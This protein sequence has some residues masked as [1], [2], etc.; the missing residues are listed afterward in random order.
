MWLLLFNPT[1]GGGKGRRYAEQSLSLMRQ[2]GHEVVEISGLDFRDAEAKFKDAV[3]AHRDQ[4]KAVIVVG[5]DGMVHMAI[6]Q[7]AGSNIPMGLVPAGTGNDFARAL[8]LNLS[9]PLSSLKLMLNSDPVKVDLGKVND[10]FFADILS[11]GFDSVVNERANRMR[12]IKGRMKYNIAILLVL[13]T[14]KPKSYQFRVDGIEFTTEAMLIAVSNGQSYG[15]GMKVTPDARIDDGLFDVMLLGPVSKLE[16]LKVFPKVF[17]G[18]HIDHP[19]VNIMRGQKVAIDSHAV[20]YADGERIGEL[21]ITA[22]ISS[23][24]LLT[25]RNG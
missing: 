1:S 18:A 23:G 5:G 14:F 10:R 17:S 7:L 6:Q 15:G 19:A 4:I 2:R 25:W 3:S 9:E 13:S 8:N 24:T 22:E 16:F 20:A 21:P 11:T 12:W